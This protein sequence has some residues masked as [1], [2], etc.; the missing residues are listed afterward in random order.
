MSNGAPFNPGWMSYPQSSQ[1]R[2]REGDNHITARHLINVLKTR[3]EGRDRGG[4]AN[5]GEWKEL[6][7]RG[8]GS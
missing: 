8:K 6:L 1:N 4:M 2:K 5:T 7:G 3:E